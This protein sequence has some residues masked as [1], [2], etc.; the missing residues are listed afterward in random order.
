VVLLAI[1]ALSMT[2]ALLYR[3]AE[4]ASGNVLVAFGVTAVATMA[5]SIH[6]LARPHMFTLLL[7]A[8]FLHILERTREGRTQ[9][10]LWLPPLMTLW[11]NLHGGFLVGL[12]LVGAYA[13]APAVK[14]AIA[15]DRAARRAEFSKGVPYLATWAASFAATFINPY[16]YKLHVH[17]FQFLR[18]PFHFL[19]VS[20]FQSLSFQHPAARYFEI[21]LVLAACAAMWNVRRGQWHYA[22]LAASWIHPALTSSRNIPIF[23]LVAAAPVAQ[24][25]AHWLEEAN[26]LRMAARIR[27]VDRLPRWHAAAAAGFL[28]LALVSLAPGASGK[29]KAEFDGQRFP[30][31]AVDFLGDKTGRIFAPDQWGAYLIYRFYPAG[32]VFVDDRSD[33]YGPA[34]EQAWLD[35]LNAKYGW[36][37]YLDRYLIDTVLLPVDAPLVGALKESRRWR[38]VYDDGMAIVFRPA[39]RTGP[40]GEKVLRS[41][42]RASVDSRG[43]G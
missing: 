13:L 22:L 12:T 43:R 6:W 9:L 3:L 37:A 28:A 31:K 26:A 18:E 7:T 10:L 20:E 36:N 2:C 40:G 24:M 1:F 25:L 30:V 21:L 34:F 27:A 4:R 32:K 16:F 19:H 33:F 35:A 39:D 17:I 11:T 29:F 41:Q 8:I 15:R 42:D 14:A 38:P 5:S 23:A